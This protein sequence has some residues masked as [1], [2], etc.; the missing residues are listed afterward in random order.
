MI[1]SRFYAVVSPNIL[2]DLTSKKRLEEIETFFE[3]LLSFS[4]E[5]KHFVLICIPNDFMWAFYSSNKMKMIMAELESL[6]TQSNIIFIN[7]DKK[8]P[9]ERDEVLSMFNSSNTNEISHRLIV[10]KMFERYLP[11]VIE[12]QDI[13]LKKTGCVLCED[14]YTCHLDHE[15]NPFILPKADIFEFIKKINLNWETLFNNCTEYNKSH[16]IYIS[17]LQAFFLGLKIEAISS[18][19]DNYNVLDLFFEDIKD[20]DLQD[21]KEISFSIYRA[22][23]YS[24]VKDR[25]ARV[26]LSIDWHPNNPAK[27]ED[28]ELFRCDVV[29][30]DKTGIKGS[31][32]KRLLIG[33]KGV[34]KYVLGFEKDHDFSNGMIKERLAAF[35][36][37][38][39]ALTQK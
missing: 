18:I 38:V 32:S 24:S 28:V 3:I 16:L 26:P 19:Q 36:T 9:C 21:I 8:E 13:T 20:L 30:S 22:L 1:S 23:N 35:N 37:L 15:F 17:Q 25:A 33:V 29:P 34:H 5:F 14:K 10:N 39:K 6:S 4:K 2:D 7:S 27:V 11:V 31:G 12:D